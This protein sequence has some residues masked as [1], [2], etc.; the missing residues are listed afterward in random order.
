M[1][2]TCK[3]AMPRAKVRRGQYRLCKP[4]AREKVALETLAFSTDA[5]SDRVS[6]RAHCS[7]LVAEQL[8]Y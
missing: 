7:L 8:K 5:V 4:A 6:A 2:R 3:S 1:H